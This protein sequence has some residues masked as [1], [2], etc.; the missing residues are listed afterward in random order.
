MAEPVIW[1]ERKGTATFRKQNANLTFS[2][3]PRYLSPLVQP[4]FTLPEQLGSGPSLLLDLR[5]SVLGQA[6]QACRQFNEFMPWLPLNSVS[7]KIRWQ[8]AVGLQV[9]LP[10]GFFINQQTVIDSD[11]SDDPT[12]RTKEYRQ[13]DASVEIPLAMVGYHHREF[14][15]WLGR[16]WEIWGPGFTGS[17]VLDAQSPPADGLGATW[18]TDRWSARYRMGRLDDFPGDPEAQARYLAGHRIDLA[19][20]P[21]VRLGLSETALVATDG[22]FPL[23]LAN[24]LLPWVLTQQE[25]R[26]KSEKTN[27][28]WA[29]D[30]AWMP[31]TGCSLYGQFLLDDA[32][33]DL[34]DRD[35]YP[36]QMGLLGGLVWSPGPASS[37]HYGLEYC[38][39]WSW[40]YV[41]RTPP[42]RYTSWAAPLGHPQGPDSEAVT[43][44]TGHDFNA[45]KVSALIWGR[46]HRHGQVH[47]GTEVSPVGSVD[48]SYPTPPVAVWWQLGANTTF[49]LAKNLQ[50][51]LNLGWTEFKYNDSP[52]VGGAIDPT[53]AATGWWGNLRITL[54]LYKEHFP[55]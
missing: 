28:F 4:G 24:P 19:L 26:G 15:A 12:S 40:T 2:A 38:R 1:P 7:A 33:V 36:D 41:H 14:T 51:T 35:T 31:R 42:V 54:P 21:D 3:P 50:L 48:L 18:T 20:S 45:G 44:F 5:A 47:L 8:T 34:E 46:W 52:T 6:G 55:L 30:A 27:I 10:H 23:W 49:P 25:D 53:E 13:I 16:N 17:L 32:M 11:P 29:V 43:V 39:L 37:W 9:N 22:P